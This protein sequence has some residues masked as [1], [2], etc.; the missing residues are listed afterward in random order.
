MSGVKTG[1]TGGEIWARESSIRE[2]R[3]EGG[4]GGGGEGKV[5]NR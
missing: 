1:K 2:T 4:G 3:E 5:G